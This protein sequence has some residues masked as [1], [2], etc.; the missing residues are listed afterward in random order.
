MTI[1]ACIMKHAQRWLSLSSIFISTSA[2][3]IRYNF[4]S[5]QKR[6]SPL[7][8]L[9]FVGWGHRWTFLVTL[10]HLWSSCV[11]LNLFRSSWI[12]FSHLMI[13]LESPIYL[14]DPRSL[15]LNYC[16]NAKEMRLMLKEEKIFQY[17]YSGSGTCCIGSYMEFGTKLLLFLLVI[18]NEW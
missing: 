6:M 11:V 14:K 8:C 12:I 4:I 13:N 1:C 18:W 2:G 16:T 3:L 9:D 7:V 17:T 15:E 10:D 5:S